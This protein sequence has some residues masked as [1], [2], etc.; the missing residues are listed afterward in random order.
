M[1]R[2]WQSN[3]R[4]VK[5]DSRHWSLVV[6]WLL[7]AR[8]FCIITIWSKM[9]VRGEMIWA[10]HFVSHRR[11]P[12]NESGGRGDMEVSLDIPLGLVVRALAS[13][14][15]N[16]SSNLIRV[17][18]FCAP[19][20]SCSGLIAF[21]WITESQ[22]VINFDWSCY[23]PR[24]PFHWIYSIINRGKHFAFQRLWIL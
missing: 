23:F 10:H 18:I 11:M 7:K 21:D 1:V 19:N 14:T 2:T 8:C 20:R 16:L 17:Q 22:L 13:E 4:W 3:Q 9:N 12:R 15:R 6:N 24:T 5:L